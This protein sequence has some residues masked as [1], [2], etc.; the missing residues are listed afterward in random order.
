MRALG[1]RGRDGRHGV[2]DVV[3][4]R[5]GTVADRLHDGDAEGHGDVLF[6]DPHH[7]P[8]AFLVNSVSI[9]NRT[10]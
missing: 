9:R 1:G 2:G 4:V 6:F 7:R 10:R 3:L 8:S 5:A